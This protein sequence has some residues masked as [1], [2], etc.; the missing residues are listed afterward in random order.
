MERQSVAKAQNHTARLSQLRR[1]GIGPSAHS[2]SNLQRHAGNQALQRLLGSDYFQA[3]LQVSSPGDPLEEE[4][5]NVADMVMRMPEPAVIQRTRMS[6]STE[7]GEE[8]LNA[9]E[10][11]TPVQRLLRAPLGNAQFL[12]QRTPDDKETVEESAAGITGRSEEKSWSKTSEAIVEQEK[13]GEKFLLMN[14]AIDQS[15]LKK[16]HLEFLNKTVFYGSLTSDP[17]A[18]I[19]IVGHA[20]S[21]GPKAR[22]DTLAK[23]R[24][25]AVADA[26]KLFGK[27]SVRIETVTSKGS[28]D[29]IATNDTVIDRARNRRVEILVTPWKPTAPV[30]EILKGL[31]KDVKPYVFTVDNFAACPFQDTVKKLVEEGF[32]PISVIKFDWEGKTADAEAFISIDDTDVWKRVLG[33]SGTIYLKSFQNN[34][35]CKVK[36]DPK[37]CEK[38]FTPTADVMGRAI[39]N[40]IAHEA[41]HALALDHVPATD[42]F[43]WSPELHPLNGKKDKT[44][45]E[46][47]LLLR[48]LQSVPE[49]FSGSQLVHMINRIKQQ[50]K[51]KPGVIEFE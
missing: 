42:N 27:N 25:K 6:G 51:A 41:G 50:R 26:L 2:I 47:V 5:D 49:S 19:T 35:I 38:V 21:T 34:E 22:N 31:Q 8:E 12:L 24:A 46:K 39:A 29:P 30:A 32:K 33:L 7:E 44:F 36:G 14:F 37:T 18:K 1:Q 10:K 48:T 20:D 43:M 45:D 4:A 3:K 9:E 23:N 15:E 13:P 11:T 40:T 28:K 16:D 17:M